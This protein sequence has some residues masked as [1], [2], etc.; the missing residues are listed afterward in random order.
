MTI[1]ITPYFIIANFQSFLGIIIS[2]LYQN[3]ENLSPSPLVP[4]TFGD[5]APATFGD[6]LGR[7]PP[8]VVA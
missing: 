5:R 8:L 1:K 2:C 6:T 3:A 7:T 4:G